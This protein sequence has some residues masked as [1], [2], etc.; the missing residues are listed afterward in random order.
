MMVLCSTSDLVVRRCLFY[1]Q[2][3]EGEPIRMF[4]IAVPDA[5]CEQQDGS[6]HEHQAHEDLKDE[7]AHAVTNP[8]SPCGTAVRFSGAETMLPTAMARTRIELR[9]MAIAARNGLI[10][11]A[12]D[13][14]MA[15][16]LYATATPISRRTVRCRCRDRWIASRIAP[17]PSP[18]R[19][20]SER[21][22]STGRSAAGDPAT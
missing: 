8:F 13:T 18:S 9:G 6:Q 20:K 11:P 3:K 7:D 10:H 15:S 22:G 19:K 12:I 5:V 2:R 4:V 17:M 1:F 16:R 14:E 21:E